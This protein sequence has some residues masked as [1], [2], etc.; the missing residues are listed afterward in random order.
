MRDE[1]VIC[2][3]DRPA[4]LVRCLSSVYAQSRLPAR[5]VVVDSSE[6]DESRLAATE[7]AQRTNATLLVLTSVPGLTLQR[8]LALDSLLDETEVVH[9]VDDDTVL[10]PDYLRAVVQQFEVEPDAVGV[11]GMIV[12]LPP[13]RPSRMRCVFLI[14]SFREGALLKS[15]VNVLSFK[16]ASPR[17]VDWLSGCSM[18][19]RVSAISGLFFDESRTGNGVGEDVDFSARARA[20]G[21]LFWTP[22]ARLE[23]LQ[24]PINRD[25]VSRLVRRWVRHRYR[26]AVDRVGPV[27]RRWVVYACVLEAIGLSVGAVRH[28]SR[29]RLETA[30]GYLLGLIDAVRGVP[31]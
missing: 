18:S 20:R 24:S 27:R 31:I 11:G 2:T 19:Y 6:S 16:S 28:R 17:R 5:I 13:H 30:G 22:N 3:K 10:E 9:F 1:L 14:D 4:D 23:H 29:S 7:S 26:L 8:N 12:G 25:Q 21:P 15:G